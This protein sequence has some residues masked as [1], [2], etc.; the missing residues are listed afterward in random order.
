M[1]V[2]LVAGTALGKLYTRH[3]H[4]GGPLIVLFEVSGHVHCFWSIEG[5]D[6]LLRSWEDH[7][8]HNI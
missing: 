1:E 2:E 8:L 5:K 7:K 3:I 4:V 6:S